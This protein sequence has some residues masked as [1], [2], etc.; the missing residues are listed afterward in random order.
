MKEKEIN[1]DKIKIKIF[2][3]HPL[4]IDGFFFNPLSLGYRDLSTLLLLLLLI[5]LGFPRLSLIGVG[6]FRE[7][8]Y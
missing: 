4:I 8:I 3:F 5:S 6:S 2:H 7:G 1:R